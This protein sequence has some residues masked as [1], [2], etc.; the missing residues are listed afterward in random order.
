MPLY[1]GA[2]QW[3]KLYPFLVYWLKEVAGTDADITTS[4]SVT[5]QPTAYFG[6]VDP[7]TIKSGIIKRIHFRIN[8][9]NAVTFILRLWQAS[10]ANDYESEMNLL[11][12]STDIIA[13][14]VDDDEYDVNGLDIPFKL[15]D[16]GKMY[17]SL[18]WSAASG[19]VQGYM[20]VSGD[21][22]E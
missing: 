21:L 17:F 2:G 4:K 16:R 11:W 3:T 13:Q 5:D 15:T 9:A 20:Q 7:D 18:E 19:N 12:S 1:C 10:I 22:K 14:C 6:N 8:N